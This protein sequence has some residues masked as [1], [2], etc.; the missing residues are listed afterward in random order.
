MPR[1]LSGV[2]GVIAGAVSVFGNTPI[3]VIKT[4]MQGRNSKIYSNSLDCAIKT[5]KLEGPTAFYKGLIPRLCRVCLDVGVTFYI[6][7][8]FIDIIGFLNSKK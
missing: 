5:W 6:F 7:D 2:F 8:L 1:V 3:D 4:R